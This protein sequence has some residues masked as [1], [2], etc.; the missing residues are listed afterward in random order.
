MKW[1]TSE[2]AQ[3]LDALMQE[4]AGKIDE[5]AT[6]RTLGTAEYGMK[7]T[8]HTT[9]CEAVRVPLFCFIVL[10]P[11]SRQPK[12]PWR[13]YYADSHARAHSPGRLAGRLIG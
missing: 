4:G 7:N 11:S 9:R 10:P 2:P 5:E 12:C 8:R 3:L 13:S 6:V 1:Q